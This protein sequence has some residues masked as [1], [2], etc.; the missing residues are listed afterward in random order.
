MVALVRTR[1]CGSNRAE[2]AFHLWLQSGSD[3]LDFGWTKVNQ[4]VKWFLPEKSIRIQ[5]ML[6]VSYGEI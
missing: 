5:Q 6:V 4:A 2:T 1:I 3:D